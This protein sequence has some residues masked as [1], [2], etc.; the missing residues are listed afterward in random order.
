MSEPT[1]AC[2]KAISESRLR[3]LSLSTVKFSNTPQCPWSVYS[4]KHISEIIIN[5]CE[6]DLIFLIACW[7]IPLS[8]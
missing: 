1:A 6:T 4:H 8:E 7:M 5:C 3:V 2:D